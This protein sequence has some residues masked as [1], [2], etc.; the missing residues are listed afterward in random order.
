M[1]LVFRFSLIII[2][3]TSCAKYNK[4]NYSPVKQNNPIF[5]IN[6]GEKNTNI[7]NIKKA[8]REKTFLELKK[9]YETAIDLL[10]KQK[11]D[12]VS[13]DSG[14]KP[15]G[16]EVSRDS[17]EVQINELYAELE[18][19]NPQTNAGYKRSLE[20]LSEINDLIYNRIAPLD[21]IISKNKEVK[22]LKGDFSFKTGNYKLTDK[23]IEEI[24][25]QVSNLEKEII[26][27]QNYLNNHNER[28]FANNTFQLMVVIDGYT[29]VQGTN[30]IN[31]KLSKDRAEEV[32]AEFRI[33][34]KKLSLKYKLIC[35]VESNGKGETLPPGVLDNG[36]KVDSKRRIC[37]IMSVVGP[38]KFFEQ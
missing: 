21:K 33:Q 20:M 10:K 3:V 6:G 18:T 7:F 27:W 14:H 22:E 38:S 31:L 28:I 35:N 15:A 12:I 23:G 29:D 2:L 17:Y 36:M 4:R 13:I 8:E 37:R 25:K 5:D 19:I 1:K 30:Q 11:T 26:E 32:E 9:V 16:I 34:L 24:A